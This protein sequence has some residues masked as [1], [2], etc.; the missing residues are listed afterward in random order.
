MSK[1]KHECPMSF[2][3]DFTFKTN[4]LGLYFGVMEVVDAMHHFFLGVGGKF[5]KDYITCIDL[6]EVCYPHKLEKRPHRKKCTSTCCG[7]YPTPMQVVSNETKADF[8][9][10]W[11]DTCLS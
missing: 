1:D 9:E 8:P 2:V 5:T 6:W 3:T 11:V 10:R 4:L 7:H